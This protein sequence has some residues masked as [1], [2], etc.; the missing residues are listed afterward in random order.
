MTDNSSK[1]ELIPLSH[2]AAELEIPIDVLM[3]WYKRKRLSILLP[4]NVAGVNY[5]NA[6]DYRVWGPH[7]RDIIIPALRPAERARCGAGGTAVK[8]RA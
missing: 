2:V 1:Q 5:V 3:I 7:L 6:D 4:I 8:R